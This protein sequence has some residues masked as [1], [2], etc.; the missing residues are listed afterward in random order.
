M[1]RLVCGVQV[2]RNDGLDLVDGR[3]WN[4]VLHNEVVNEC[5][6]IGNVG[7]ITAGQEVLDVS[8]R[9][10]RRRLRVDH[11]HA[12]PKGVKVAQCCTLSSLVTR[13]KTLVYAVG[14][15]IRVLRL[16]LEVACQIGTG[17]QKIGGAL[18]V[19]GRTF[20]LL[21]DVLNRLVNRNVNRNEVR[22]DGR[23]RI[24]DL[25]GGRH[26]IR[27]SNLG[28]LGGHGRTSLVVS[29]DGRRCGVGVALLLL[30]GG[31]ARSNKADGKH[32][33]DC[34]CALLVDVLH[35]SC[36]LSVISSGVTPVRVPPFGGS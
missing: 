17:D 35:C 10:G 9:I 26:V 5:L 16:A 32:A 1:V 28:R 14:N 18:L 34:R 4:L 29:C 7:N 11:G 33:G 8:E 27:G 22:R 20:D 2:R 12:R 30:G 36:F 19:V 21:G 15:L 23:S 13:R 6:D 31:A 24:V 3:N 25:V